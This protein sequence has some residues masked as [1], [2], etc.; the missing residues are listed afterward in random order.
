M[1]VALPYEGRVEDIDTC[2]IC[3]SIGGG[4]W[5]LTEAH[6]LSSVG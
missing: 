1:A 6:F 3:M 4:V 5:R 2:I